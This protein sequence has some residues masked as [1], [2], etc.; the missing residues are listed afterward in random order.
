M[1]LGRPYRDAMPDAAA[2]AELIRC[3]GT[4]FDPRVVEEFARL[5]A[6][7]SPSVQKS[8]PAQAPGVTP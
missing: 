7:Q 3:S 5:L 6:D 4:Q 1:T 2:L 8:A